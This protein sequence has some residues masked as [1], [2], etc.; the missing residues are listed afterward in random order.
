MKKEIME[1]KK[2][3]HCKTYSKTKYMKKKKQIKKRKKT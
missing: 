2:K 3:N 1:I